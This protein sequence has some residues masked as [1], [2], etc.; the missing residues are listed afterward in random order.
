MGR[1]GY[2]CGAS[3]QKWTRAGLRDV[4]VHC[5]ITVAVLTRASDFYPESLVFI[6]NLKLLSFCLPVHF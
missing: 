1:V 5:D 3:L 6:Y 2:Q 4:S